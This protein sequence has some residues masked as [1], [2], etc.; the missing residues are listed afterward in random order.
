MLRKEYVGNHLGEGSS[1]LKPGEE[2]VSKK[3]GG[4]GRRRKIIVEFTGEGGNVG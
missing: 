2:G 3:V 1:C 4:G